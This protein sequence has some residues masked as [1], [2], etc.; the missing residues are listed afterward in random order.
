[1][2]I[3]TQ[4]ASVL[5]FRLLG[6]HPPPLPSERTLISDATETLTFK[7]QSHHQSYMYREQYLDGDQA[8]PIGKIKCSI[9][10]ISLIVLRQWQLIVLGT[11]GRG[12]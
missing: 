12:A 1:M 6:Y 2:L 11:V 5:I 3:T 4:S 7:I 9:F 8:R 10:L